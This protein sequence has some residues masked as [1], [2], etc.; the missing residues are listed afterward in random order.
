MRFQIRTLVRF[1]C[2]CSDVCN[3]YCF[4]IVGH[5]GLVSLYDMPHANFH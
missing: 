1:V 4:D 5:F 2:V 3:V